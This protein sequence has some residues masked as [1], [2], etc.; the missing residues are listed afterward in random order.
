MCILSINVFIND[1]VSA[2]GIMEFLAITW[3]DWK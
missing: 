1:V 3:T 2:I